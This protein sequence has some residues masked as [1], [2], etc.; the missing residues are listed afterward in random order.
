MSTASGIWSSA[1]VV[2]HPPA[3][4]IAVTSAEARTIGLVDRGRPP[5]G[6]SAT[7]C[8]VVVLGCLLGV[9]LLLRGEQVLLRLAAGWT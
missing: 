9:L 1:L 5:P 8:A 7:L 6:V 4:A 3:P 2:P